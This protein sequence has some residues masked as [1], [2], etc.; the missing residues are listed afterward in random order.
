[1][2]KII[3]LITVFISVNA[4]AQQTKTYNETE[5]PKGCIVRHDK[6]QEPEK[7]LHYVLTKKDSIALDRFQVIGYDPKRKAI[8]FT[9][10]N[11]DLYKMGIDTTIYKK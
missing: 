2:K 3:L 11:I 4:T 10:K 6:L 5:C 8:L 1:M 9:Y 7:F